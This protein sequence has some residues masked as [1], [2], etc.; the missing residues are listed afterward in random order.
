MDRSS[1]AACAA[2]AWTLLA[3]A[4]IPALPHGRAR[5]PNTAVP[6]TYGEPVD[7]T[8][9]AQM[10]WSEFFADPKLNTLIEI[11]LKNN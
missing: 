1:L 5:A 11:A 7:A 3:S 9:S 4:C 6:A 10:K 8:N 2:L